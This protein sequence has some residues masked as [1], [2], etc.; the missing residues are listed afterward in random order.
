MMVL[1]GS[2]R[3]IGLGRKGDYMKEIIIDK[4]SWHYRLYESYG[5]NRYE[6]QTICDY[7]NGVLLGTFVAFCITLI[8]GFFSVGAVDFFI[9]VYVNHFIGKVEI[10]ASGEVF[11]FLMT[12]GSIALAFI[13]MIGNAPKFIRESFPFMAYI[14]LRNQFCVKVKVV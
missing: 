11:A 14:S 6:P 12:F 3:I 1:N 10:N 8:G 5:G 2:Q 13:L 9:W 7:T 4:N